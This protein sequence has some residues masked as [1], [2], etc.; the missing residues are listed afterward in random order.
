M[1]IYTVVFYHLVPV[2][3]IHLL[4]EVTGQVSQGLK[5]HPQQLL[6]PLPD[7]K[8]GG[9]GHL[10][11]AVTGLALLAL[12]TCSVKRLRIAVCNAPLQLSVID[13]LKLR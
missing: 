10:L 12:S 3:D 1:K 4:Q 11:L 6:D 7:E 13:S 5:L 2:V 8:A 9:G